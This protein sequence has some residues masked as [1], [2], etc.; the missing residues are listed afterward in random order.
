MASSL[1]NITGG[2]AITRRGPS[3]VA[4][5]LD[6]RNW[7]TI[8]TQQ[9]DQLAIDI[10]NGNDGGLPALGKFGLNSTNRSLRLDLAK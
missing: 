8:G 3:L 1:A 4:G 10:G 2:L 6:G 9:G 5:D 7:G